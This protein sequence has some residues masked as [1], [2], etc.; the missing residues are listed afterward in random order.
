MRLPV[1]IA[2]AM[3][4]AV[5]MPDPITGS[6]GP[7][8]AEAAVSFDLSLNELVRISPFVVLGRV[9]EHQSLWEEDETQGR[10]IVT[11]TRVRVERSLGEKEAANEV[12]VR[13]FG[14]TV[15]S[16]GQRVDG[17]AV[18]L[19]DQSALLFLQPR[20]DGTHAVS[21]MALGHFPIVKTDDGVLRLSPSP[22][23]GLVL[24]QDKGA[25]THSVRDALTGKTVDEAAALIQAARQAH[26]R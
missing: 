6:L 10:R 19:K 2:I 8:P 4:V 1:A 15:G 9:L 11:Y 23:P 14:G 5:S 3:G 7:S 18:L 16:I 25:I 13:T 12:W 20:Q 17:E 24:R 22:Q 26:A 21:G